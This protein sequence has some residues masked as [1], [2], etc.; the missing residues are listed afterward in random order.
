MAVYTTTTGDTFELIARKQYGTEQESARIA[1]ANPGLSEPLT[2][3]V[4]VVIPD[5]PSAPQDSPQ[6]APTDEANEVSVRIDGVRFRFW[7]S[8]TLARSIDAVGTAGFGTPFNADAPGFKETFK[9]FSFKSFSVNV[10]GD[11]LFTGIMVSVSPTVEATQKTLSVSGYSLPGVLNDSVFPASAYPIEYNGMT[12]QE[13]ATAAAEIFGL[14]VEFDEDSGPVFERVAVDPA[15]KVLT[16][17]SDLAKQRNFVISSTPSGALR[18]LRSVEPGQPVAILEQGKSPLL[19]VTPTFDPQTYFSHIT[20]IAPTVIGLDGTQHTVKNPFLSSAIRAETFK[21]DDSTGAD[22]K[23]AVDAKMG[24][25]FG[26]MASYSVTVATWRDPSGNLWEPNTT[27]NVTA[28]DAMIYNAYEFILRSVQ[29]DR[30]AQ[31][32]TATL[33]LVLPGAFSGKIPEVLPWE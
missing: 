29:F 24:R 33:D 21:A 10:G 7:N 4:V 28:P 23:A 12:L 3:G 14:S 5:L 25:M 19:S 31:S 1:R 8:I 17:L 16:F 9:P 30:D 18:F 27:I 11:P 6:N 32:E 20:G 22:V 15:Q 13:I 26:N 2:A